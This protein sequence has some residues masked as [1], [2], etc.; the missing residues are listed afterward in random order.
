M[1]L[2]RFS[3]CRAMFWAFSM[4]GRE[5][6]LTRRRKVMVLFWITLAQGRKIATNCFPATSVML[7]VWL[8]MDM[9]SP[10]MFITL[11]LTVLFSFWISIFTF[12]NFPL[13]SIFTF[14]NFPLI[15]IFTFS[16]FPFANSIA[17]LISPLT[18]VYTSTY[19]SSTVF[20]LFFSYHSFT[21]LATNVANSVPSRNAFLTTN[22]P[23]TMY[24]LSFGTRV[25]FR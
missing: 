10:V 14:S 23:L 19:S 24:S 1:N 11:K 3:F 20:S 4:S 25:L 5:M 8:K 13:I 22:F 9:I 21:S 17:L 18:K 12:S 15:S 2:L 7:A 6:F 16:N